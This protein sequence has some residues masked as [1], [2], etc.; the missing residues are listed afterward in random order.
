MLELKIAMG[1]LIAFACI[2]IATVFAEG[3]MHLLKL[4]WIFIAPSEDSRKA[5]Y[6]R[7]KASGKTGESELRGFIGMKD[8]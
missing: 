6:Y 3:F 7:R 1:I 8:H 4:V 2:T 5:E